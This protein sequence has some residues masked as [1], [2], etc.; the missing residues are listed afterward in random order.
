[1]PLFYNWPIGLRFELGVN[2][3]SSPSYFAEVTQRAITLYEFLF[4]KEDQ[5]LVL[6]LAYTGEGHDFPIPNYCF[7][8]ISAF[9]PKKIQYEERQAPNEQEDYEDKW[10][11]A[12]IPTTVAQVC[13]ENIFEALAHWD[14]A[15]RKPQ[16]EGEVY[17]INLEKKCILNMYDDRGMDIIAKDKQILIPIYQAYKDWILDYDRKRIEQAF[18]NS[19]RHFK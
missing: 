16:I 2:S 19:G 8:Q 5:I 12:T 13:H 15:S 11:M 7:D 1:M 10:T 3:T 18:N 6:F 4:E 14:F 9:H 17:F